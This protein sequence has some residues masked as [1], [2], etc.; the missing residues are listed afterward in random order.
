MKACGVVVEYNPF[1][2]GHLY[3]LQKAKEL[4]KADVMIAV[5][6]GNFLQRGEPAIIDKFY[7][8]KAAL[9]AGA[10]I[11]IELPYAY[12]VQSSELFAKGA[13]LSL[14]ELGISSL[15]FGSELGEIGPFLKLFSQ[16]EKNKQ[17][18][19]ETIKK[20][21]QKGNSYPKA[22]SEALQKLGIANLDM[23]K[24]NNILGFSYIKTILQNNLPIE[25]F[26]IKRVYNDFHEEEITNE[27]ASAT[28]IRKELVEHHF[29][30]KVKKSV[31]PFSIEQLQY[32]EK[33]T[34][35]WHTWDEYFPY[36]IYQIMTKS[37]DEL[38]F[39]HGVDEGIE[40]RLNKLFH[41]V[42]SFDE[43]IHKIKTKRYTYVRLQR[44]FVHILT[45]TK[46]EE[47]KVITDK[48]S[49]P[50][51]RL[52]GMSETGRMYLNERKKEITVPLITSLSKKYKELTYLDERASQ[53][54]YSILPV[55]LRNELWKQEFA[56]PLRY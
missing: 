23:M 47:V 42:Q 12:A 33:K 45:N 25:P 17:T 8:T 35:K 49:V 28:S 52:L 10:D 7:R 37:T 15:C 48:D 29:S 22:N 39:I 9:A 20:L 53:I 18:Y 46:K 55:E 5:M 44:M 21:L 6:S 27:I 1:H 11:V 19:D 32:Y 50:Y 16:L 40:K 31:P 41:H 13:I 2:N 56:L 4:T 38:A 26:T 30:E 54:Y 24:P 51:V 14:H 3:H 34:K 43:L 36:L